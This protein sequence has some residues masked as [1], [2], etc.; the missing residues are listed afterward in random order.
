MAGTWVELI[1]FVLKIGRVSLKPKIDA[2][3]EF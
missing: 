2:F 1:L 3:A